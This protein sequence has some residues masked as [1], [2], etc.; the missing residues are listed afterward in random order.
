VKSIFCPIPNC[1]VQIIVEYKT[2]EEVYEIMKKH[3]M[4][5]KMAD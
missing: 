3:L 4:T 2:I 5:H 1:R